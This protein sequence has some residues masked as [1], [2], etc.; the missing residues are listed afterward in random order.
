MCINSSCMSPSPARPKCLDSFS[1]LDPTGFALVSS[2]SSKFCSAGAMTLSMWTMILER[3]SAGKDLVGVTQE[4]GHCPSRAAQSHTR[5]CACVH[6][7]SCWTS[8]VKLTQYGQLSIVLWHCWPLE[9]VDCS[10]NLCCFVPNVCDS[11]NQQLYLMRSD[12]CGTDWSVQSLDVA[13]FPKHTAVRVCSVHSHTAGLGGHSPR[14]PHMI[15]LLL[16]LLL[17]QCSHR[18]HSSFQPSSSMP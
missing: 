2:H 10:V 17:F 4:R 8:L 5:C 14:P 11:V 3:V 16:L 13:V 6:A 7:F 15:L 12:L 1:C 9:E 18:H